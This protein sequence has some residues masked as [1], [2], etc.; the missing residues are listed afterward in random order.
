MH[1]ISIQPLLSCLKEDRLRFITLH[2]LCTL[3]SHKA[4]F[5]VQEYTPKQ[6]YTLN[7]SEQVPLGQGEWAHIC[8]I[9]EENNKIQ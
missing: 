3:K 4:L 5:S 1:W 2:H 9:K 8:M 7:T 6:G